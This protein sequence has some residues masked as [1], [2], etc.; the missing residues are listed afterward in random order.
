M[1]NHLNSIVRMVALALLCIIAMPLEAAVQA[2][3]D[4]SRIVEGETVTLTILTDDPRQNLDTDFS[5]LE[6][7]FQL[8]DR[9]SETQLSIVNGRQ[10]AVV[11]LLLTLEPKT[12]GEFE[13]PR[14]T[15]GA[16]S[17]RA[18]ALKVDPAPELE[19][20]TQPPVFIEVEVTPTEG[21]YFVH[22]QL[23]LIV[24]VFYQQNLTE[25]AIGQ[26]EPSPAAVRLMQETPYQAERGGERYRVLERNYAVFPERSGEL[27]IPPMELTGRLV[28]RRTSNVWQPAVRGRRV[29]VESDALTLNIEPKPPEFSGSEWQPAREFRMTQQVSSGD[30]LRV[31]E[32][33]T[34]TVIIDAVGLEE[35]MIVEPV[36]PEL[37]GAR[38][39]PDQ[40]QGITRDDGQWALGHKEFRY[41]VVPEQEGELV[42]PKLSVEWWDTQNNRAQTAVLP[43][44]VIQV[45]PSALVPPLTAPTLTEVSAIRDANGVYAPAASGGPGYWRWLTF[46]FAGLWLLTLLAVLLI[47]GRKIDE[48]VRDKAGDRVS[49]NEAGVL[50]VLENAC[51]SG[52]IRQARRGLQNWLRKF[53][54]APGNG[55]L[56]EFAE[57]ID[58][59]GLRNSIYSLDGEG[60]RPHS[61]QAWNGKVFWKQLDS[62]RRSRQASDKK[63]MPSP[64]DLYAVEN[65]TPQ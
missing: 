26:P 38:I 7:D 34:R 62:W 42:L 47:R 51:N 64:T 33:V 40:P 48:R 46:L 49:V 13:I 24:R 43:S 30:T 57:E 56:L 1:L 39:Y 3:L 53:G 17:T 12:V 27:T 2:E 32:P 8:L 59:A 55:S 45:L 6:K 54:P 25:A 21:P 50:A 35:N 61:R 31:G 41:A 9:R 20:G 36:W 29:K 16:D 15:F 60:F 5:A 11:R 19:P 58:D 14:L 10:T 22:A 4:R 37:P 23:S 44:H 52:D 28:E 18:M 65:R 63:N